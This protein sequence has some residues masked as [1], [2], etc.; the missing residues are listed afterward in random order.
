V[1][2]SGDI[3]LI[4]ARRLTLEG[5]HVVGVFEVKPE[6]SGLQRNISQCLDDFDIPLYLSKTVTAIH[7]KD[8]IIGV[9]VSQVNQQGVAI[10]NTSE[11]IECDCLILS[12]GLIPENELGQML[13]VELDPSTRGPFV[14]QNMH[15]L[16]PGV[17]ACGNSVHVHDLVDYVS[18]SGCTAGKSAAAWI[19]EKRERKLLPLRHSSDFLY[20]VP[21]F[22]DSADSAPC[23]L[24]FRSKTTIKNAVRL[25]AEAKDAKLPIA[26]FAELR[27]SEME[28]VEISLMNL[29]SKTYVLTLEDEHDA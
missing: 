9:T 4:M 5:A 3:G 20:H 28:R 13:G 21:Q 8:R 29:E 26:K 27:P 6:P 15:T 14:D 22:L 17:F 16:V 25:I 23:M 7:G 11:Y 10:D 24:Y 2:G 12:V 1:L 19:R 18:E